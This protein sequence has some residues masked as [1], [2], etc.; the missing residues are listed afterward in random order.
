MELYDCGG[1]KLLVSMTGRE[2]L[3]Q[4]IDVLVPGALQRRQ[5]APQEWCH[6]LGLELL[7]ASPVGAVLWLRH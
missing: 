6:S 5:T 4:E 1:D 7:V 3:P 2:K